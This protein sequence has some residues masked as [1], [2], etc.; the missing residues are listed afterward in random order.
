MSDA[1]ITKHRAGRTITITRVETCGVPE[2]EIDMDSENQAMPV[3]V[4][5]SLADGRRFVDMV[6]AL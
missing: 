1:A 3:V 5:R 6:G 4:S 2:W